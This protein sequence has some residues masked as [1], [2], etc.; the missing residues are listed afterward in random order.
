MS[1][2][3][4]AVD[5]G[6]SG[7]KVAVVDR[8]G[9]VRAAAY[10]PLATRHTPDGGAEQDADEWWRALGRATCAGARERGRCAST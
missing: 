3:V 8:E 6:T 1:P 2:Y 7:L 4:L 9:I 5:L 10:E